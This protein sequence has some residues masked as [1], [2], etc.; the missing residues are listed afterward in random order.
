M[1]SASSIY[2]LTILGYFVDIPFFFR[3]DM[4]SNNNMEIEMEKKNKLTSGL[5]CYV[6]YISIE[7]KT[8]TSSF[9][10]GKHVEIKIMH[11]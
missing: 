7:F 6:L 3:N 10:I 4:Q 8:N 1:L 2:L 5:I 11:K 9:S